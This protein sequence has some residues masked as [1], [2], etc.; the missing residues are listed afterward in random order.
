VAFYVIGQGKDPARVY[1]LLG[2]LGAWEAA[3]YPMASGG[4]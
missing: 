2:G 1:A 3:G 4:E